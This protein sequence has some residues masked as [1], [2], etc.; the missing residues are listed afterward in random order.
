MAPPLKLGSGP[1]L[2]CDLARRSQ[3]GPPPAKDAGDTNPL[4]PA[5]P[6]S[7]VPC[8]GIRYSE[9]R[10]KATFQAVLPLGSSV[11]CS[12]SPPPFPTLHTVLPGTS[13]FPESL[14]FSMS[15]TFLGSCTPPEPPTLPQVVF[16]YALAIFKYNEEEILRLQDSLEIYQYLRFFTKTI[17]DSR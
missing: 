7:L 6:C 5:G 13:T 8:G 17:C 9:T 11:T 15:S 2:A 1:N 14:G 10:Y 4:T 16:R 3:W 12:S